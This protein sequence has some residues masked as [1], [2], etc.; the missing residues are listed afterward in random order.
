MRVLVLEDDKN[1]V[2][3][4][5]QRMLEIGVV[6]DYVDK[7]HDAIKLLGEKE[8]DLIF[9]DHDLGGEVFVNVANSNTGS[10]VARWISAHPVTCPVVIHSLNP[11]G[12]DNMKKYIPGAVHVPFVW[13]EDKFHATVKPG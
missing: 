7:A 12:A 2:R 4:F 13:Q 10:E 3:E 11:V 5:K 6:A 9:L 1:R 8:Y